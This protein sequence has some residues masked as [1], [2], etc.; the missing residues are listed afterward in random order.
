MKRMVVL[1]RELAGY[2]VHALNYLADNHDV[3]IDIIAYPVKSE[4]PFRFEFSRKINRFDRSAFAD[5]QLSKHIAD[6]KY[7]LIFCGGWTDK[8]YIK[9]VAANRHIPS[10]LGFDKQWEGGLKDELRTTYLRLFIRGHF[11]F[12]FVPGLE[13]VQFARKIGFRENEIKQGAY[14]CETDRFSRVY[15]KRAQRNGAVRKWYYVGRYA[16]EK[17]IQSLCQTF[18]TWVTEE[19]RKD[20]LHC[21]GTGPLFDSRLQHPQIIHHG[22]QQPAEMEQAML[23]GDIFILPSLYEP[24]GVVVNEFAVA[25]Y[26]LVL[27]NKVGARTALLTE[28]NGWLLEDNTPNGI[29]ALFE[30]VSKSTNEELKTMGEVSRSLGLK[31]DAKQYAD[32]ILGMMK[33]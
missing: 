9:A 30:K 18:V 10:L 5:G 32:S 4:A 25:G 29:I 11:D 24:W 7:D 3:Q 15:Q 16:P 22:F 19:N 23:D 6:S 13:Q 27:S 21:F 20:E 17:N 31:L 8:E 1:Y 33:S 14:I 26:P 28:N 2:I 12:A